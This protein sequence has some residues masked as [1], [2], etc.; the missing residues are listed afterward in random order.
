MP[1]RDDVLMLVC[2]VLGVGLLNVPGNIAFNAWLRARCHRLK[3]LP[4]LPYVSVLVPARNE[5]HQIVRC[6]ESLL[7]QDYPNVEVIALNDDS[8]DATGELLERL[9]AQSPRLRVLHNHTPVPPG[10]NGKSRAC[11]LLASHAR[12]EWLLFVDADTVHQPHAMRGGVL[13]ALALQVDLFGV[14]PH[15]VLGTWGERLFVPA[16]FALIDNAISMWRLYALQHTRL[17]NAAAIGQWLLVRRAAHIESGVHQAIQTAILDDVALGR[18][19]KSRGYRIALA[20]GDWV[21]CRMYCSAGEV[22][23]GFS[24]NAPAVLQDSIGLSVVFVLAFAGSPPAWLAVGLAVTN[25]AMVCCG[26]DNRSGLPRFT[27]SRSR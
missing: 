24:K 2:A 22:V 7:A 26:S 25:F 1:H 17:L 3:P 8:E 14:V 6:V 11:Q 23:R 9:A 15:Q 16:G 27:R 19:V 20:D 10:V 18:L 21:S 5:E 4:S 12:G 13:S